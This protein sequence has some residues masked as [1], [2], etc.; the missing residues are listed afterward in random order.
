MLKQQKHMKEN[1]VVCVCMHMLV[2]V[3]IY[4]YLKAN[5]RILVC[6]ELGV[7]HLSD[8]ANVTLAK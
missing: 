6:R 7:I 1:W 2:H 8:R 5:V 3:G 4:V